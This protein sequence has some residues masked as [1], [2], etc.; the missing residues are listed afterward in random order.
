MRNEFESPG[1]FID[2]EVEDEPKKGL[3]DEDEDTEEES[4]DEEEETT[5]E[6]MI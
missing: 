4:E 1:T 2:E 3:P 6:E 5:E